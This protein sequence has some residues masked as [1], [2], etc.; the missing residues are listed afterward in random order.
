MTWLWVVLAVAAIIGMMIGSV[1]LF[2][3]VVTR[4]RRRGP[5]EKT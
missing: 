5:K 3:Y 4:Q 2:N 1:E